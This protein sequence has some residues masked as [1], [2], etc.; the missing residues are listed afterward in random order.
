MQAYTTRKNLAESRELHAE[1]GLALQTGIV[2][3]EVGHQLR[4]DRVTKQDDHEASEDQRVQ[5]D[6][7]DYTEVLGDASIWMADRVVV[8]VMTRSLALLI[9]S[10]YLLDQAPVRR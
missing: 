9:A 6:C 3:Q 8:D 2:L 10:L 5:V 4:T 1:A 7:G